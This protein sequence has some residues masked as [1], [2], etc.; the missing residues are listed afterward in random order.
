MFAKAANR[1]ERV[2]LRKHKATS[3]PAKDFHVEEDE[4]RQKDS[5]G[6]REHIQA[7]YHAMRYLERPVSKEDGYMVCLS[8]AGSDIEES[9]PWKIVSLSKGLW[10]LDHPS[11]GSW[12][13]QN[14]ALPKLI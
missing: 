10:E 3:R 9:A 7:P 12:S 5:D 11:L 8:W 4:Y 6:N 2:P 1:L 13:I 14:E